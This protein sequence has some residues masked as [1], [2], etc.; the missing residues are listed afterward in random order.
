MTYP[1][2]RNTVGSSAEVFGPVL[3][4]LRFSDEGEALAIA[5][6]TRYGLA[7]GVWT[8]D[9]GRAIR[10]SERLKAGTVWINNYRAPSFTTP[11]GGYKASGIG[12]EGGVEAFNEYTQIKSVWIT[13][14]PKMSDPFIR[15]Y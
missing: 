10:M 15:R 6:D 3:C 13:S 11:F 5:N 12:R 4:V 9:L 2:R 1:S 14:D 7:A 8:R